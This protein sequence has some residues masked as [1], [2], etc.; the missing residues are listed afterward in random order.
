M[1]KLLMETHKSSKYQFYKGFY[2][3]EEG[4][5]SEN[6]PVKEIILDSIKRHKKR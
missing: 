1:L 3:I 5:L 4:E 2:L 6:C